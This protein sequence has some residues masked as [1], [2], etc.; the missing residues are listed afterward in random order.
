[1]D[2]DLA[3]LKGHLGLCSYAI[4]YWVSHILA[5]LAKLRESEE[6]SNELLHQ[7]N[8]LIESTRKRVSLPEQMPKETKSRILRNL[9][10]ENDIRSFIQTVSAF[11]IEYLEAERTHS[12][13][14]GQTKFCRASELLC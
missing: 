7:V 2:F 11:S 4:E 10:D 13:A 8:M 5:Y 3:V 14:E 12:S 1:M 6:L 9:G